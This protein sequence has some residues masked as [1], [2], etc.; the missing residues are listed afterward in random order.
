M[1]W[2][3][4]RSR[5][6]LI[7]SAPLDA[8]AVGELTRNMAWAEHPEELVVSLLKVLV[9]AGGL[10]QALC[11]A[12]GDTGG[13]LQPLAGFPKDASAFPAQ[14]ME[15]LENPLVYGVVGGQAYLVERLERLVHVGESFDRLREVVSAE[16]GVLVVPLRDMKRSVF[17][18]LALVGKAECLL[19]TRHAPLWQIILQLHERLLARLYQRLGSEA[20][21][22]NAKAE[23]ERASVRARDRAARLL[24]A[25]FVGV[26]PAVRQLRSEMLGMLDSTLAILITG[27]TGAG[28]DHAAWLIHQASSRGGKFVP[29]NCAAIPKDLIEAELFGSERG[30]FTGAH[31]SR[32]GLVADADGGTLFLDEIGDMPPDLQGRLLRLLNEKKYRPVGSNEE[33][34]SDF[35]LICATHRSLPARIAEGLFREDLYFRIRQMTLHVPAL[36]DRPEDIPV[37]AEHTL[38]QF[39]R[40]R[41]A[42]IPGFSAQALKL[43]ESHQFPGNVRELRSL[44]LVAAELTGGGTA[45]KSSAIRGIQSDPYPAGQDVRSMSAMEEFWRTKDLPGALAS[46]ECRL[47]GERLRQLN[48]SRM[49]AAQSLGIPK[50]TLAR[51]CQQWN[52]DRED[53][54]S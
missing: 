24:A 42:N 2:Q 44:V 47:I 7:M 39:N 45:I 41:Q 15:E 19:E 16:D 12:L 11:Y 14:A 31:Q 49:L 48:G 43:L 13:H 6:G 21:V 9:R 52:L 10:S 30:A 17:A 26:S 54:S 53:T 38:R 32:K 35:R 27:E 50:R 1:E 33:R 51:K 22:R 18:V 5:A 29:V 37:L 34:Q 23:Q 3:C 28:K 8:L 40:E 36:R 4:F 25:E 46:L 20:Q